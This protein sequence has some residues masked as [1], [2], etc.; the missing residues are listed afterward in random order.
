MCS[1][2][3][4]FGG[5]A[6]AVAGSVLSGGFAGVA[7]VVWACGSV[8]CVDGYCEGAGG[9]VV[10]IPANSLASIVGGPN[11]EAGVNRWFQAVSHVGRHP[12]H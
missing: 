8:A 1:Q 9:E 11:S 5:G 6:A 4:G 10:T 2:G 12:I 3:H 7:D